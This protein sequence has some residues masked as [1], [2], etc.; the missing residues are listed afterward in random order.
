MQNEELEEAF[1]KFRER[2]ERLARQRMNPILSRRLSPEDVV[3]ETMAAVCRDESPF[4]ANP[5]LPLYFKLRTALLQTL[6]QIERR[7]IGADMPATTIIT[8]AEVISSIC[9]N[10][11]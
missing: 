6:A 11:L 9:A 7:H 10:N 1:L 5:D 2:L 4:M 8:F 3:Q